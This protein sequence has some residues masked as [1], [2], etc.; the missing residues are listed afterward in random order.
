MDRNRGC[1][2]VYEYGVL[3]NEQLGISSLIM[4]PH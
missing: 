3:I 1:H 4:Y 2:S